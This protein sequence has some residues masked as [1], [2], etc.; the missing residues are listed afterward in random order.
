[1]QRYLIYPG[2]GCSNVNNSWLVTSLT[3]AYITAL[4]DEGIVD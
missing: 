1:M 4:H 2:V 3:S